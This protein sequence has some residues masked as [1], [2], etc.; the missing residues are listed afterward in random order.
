[1]IHEPAH[2]MNT[3][4]TCLPTFCEFEDIWLVVFFGSKS[5]SLITDA[6]CAPVGI[7]NYF[8]NEFA[9][10]VSAIGVFDHVRTRFINSDLELLHQIFVEEMARPPSTAAVNYPNLDDA[11][12][13][14]DQPLLGH[15]FF[16]FIDWS[17]LPGF[18]CGVPEDISPTT[19]GQSLVDHQGSELGDATIPPQNGID[20]TV[21]YDEDQPAHQRLHLP[22]PLGHERSE[23]ES[24]LMLTSIAS[25][26]ES[27][28]DSGTAEVSAVHAPALSTAQEEFRLPIPAALPTCPT[29]FLSARPAQSRPRRLRRVTR[30]QLRI[31]FW[32]KLLKRATS[33]RRAVPFQ[34]LEEV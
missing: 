9:R 12:E 31:W 1:M 13:D 22:P 23:D 21:P 34:E 6:D 28:D 8:D 5:F 18:C 16:S 2:N 15:D 33:T 14:D 24:T 17:Y 10:F 27:F 20:P 19:Q 25:I 26:P 30:R 7:N 11:T 32:K 4:S 29:A 3:K